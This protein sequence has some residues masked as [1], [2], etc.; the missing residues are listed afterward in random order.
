MHFTIKYKLL[1]LTEKLLIGKYANNNI[2]ADLKDKDSHMLLL[3][4]AE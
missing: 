4:A 1:Y 2:T 3:L